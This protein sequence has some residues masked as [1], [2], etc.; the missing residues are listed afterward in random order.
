MSRVLIADDQRL[1]RDGL[2]AI[3]QQEEDIEVVGV[4]DNGLEAC[5][6][7][8]SL[9][10]DLVLMDIQMPLMD[11]IQAMKTIKRDDPG[12]SILILTTF[13]EERYIV[14]AMAGGA[15]GFLMKDLPADKV[16]Q[17]V[18][19][20]MDGH[21]ILPAQVAAKLANRLSVFSQWEDGVLDENKL[22]RQDLAFTERERM[23][24]ALMIDGYSN[25]QISA[26]LFMS[27]GTV[28]NYISVIYGKIQTNDRM[29][30][31]FRLKELMSD[32]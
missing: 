1:F 7:A 17:T 32:G 18:R 19:D 27:E 11:G 12:I 16:V 3:L 26:A 4:C 6:A 21:V 30:A 13:A 8:A 23:I 24:I 22:K 2:Q 31:I 14:D 28:R 9:K 15:D 10:P 20:A 25:R 5:Y 29:T